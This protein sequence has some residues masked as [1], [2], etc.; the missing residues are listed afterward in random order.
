LI[1]KGDR[2]YQFQAFQNLFPPCIEKYVI[3]MLLIQIASLNLTVP[4][5]TVEKVTLTFAY[6]KFT[7]AANLSTGGSL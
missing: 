6:V 2:T 5:L 1:V 7:C 4:G 3:T